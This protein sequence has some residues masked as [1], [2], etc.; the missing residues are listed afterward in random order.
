MKHANRSFRRHLRSTVAFEIL[1]TIAVD[2]AAPMLIAH[3]YEICRRK[4]ITEAVTS[5]R[6]SLYIYLYRLVDRGFVRLEGLRR[7]MHVVLTKEG[8]RELQRY[9]EQ[10]ETCDRT[11]V[12]LPI[13]GELGMH[14]KRSF[15][16]EKKMEMSVRQRK[17]IHEISKKERLFYISY[18]L[19][20]ELEHERGLLKMALTTLGFR[21][22]HESFYVGA[23][24][25]EQLIDVAESVGILPFLAWGR[26]TPMAA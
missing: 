16:L 26:L 19:P 18:D 3:L 25:L 17:E 8:E 5:R 21:M 7:H 14:R 20:K 15:L 10:C 9:L 23:H 6:S 22:M 1:K 11:S 24:N 4:S 12:G 13:H 2:I